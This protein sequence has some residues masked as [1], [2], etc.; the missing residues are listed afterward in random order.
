MTREGDERLVDSQKE[1]LAARAEVAN[2]SN[3]SFF[4]SIHVNA[5][6]LKFKGAA[7]VNGM[8]VYYMD[9]PDMYEN[10]TPKQL[11]NLIADNICAS[12]GIKLNFI[13]D[14]NYSVLRNTTMPAVL[15]ET[16]YI[17][18]KEDYQRLT[19]DEFRAATAKGIADG[20][21]AA[22]QEVGAF[23]HNGELYVFKEAESE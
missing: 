21:M 3:A 17:T 23:D 1:D 15:I 7:S 16:A 9:K 12:S 13:K 11:A 2:K 18:N 5:Y 19:T 22:L 8:E 14:N 10:F 4:V 20:I 6:D